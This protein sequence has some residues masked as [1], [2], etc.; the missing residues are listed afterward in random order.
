MHTHHT[1]PHH[2][3]THPHPHTHTHTHTTDPTHHTCLVSKCDDTHSTPPSASQNLY[4]RTYVPSILQCFSEGYTTLQKWPGTLKF[5]KD[6]TIVMW[7]GQST[8]IKQRFSAGSRMERGRGTSLDTNFWQ[9]AL[10]L[11]RLSEDGSKRNSPPPPPPSQS[12][13]S[14]DSTLHKVYSYTAVLLFG[15]LYSSTTTLMRDVGSLTGLFND[16]M[17]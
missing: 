4:I 6:T 12:Y 11:A 17:L 8:R 10:L 15:G 1:T 5:L 3:P 7:C 2:T 13:N 16:C 9:F 14:Q